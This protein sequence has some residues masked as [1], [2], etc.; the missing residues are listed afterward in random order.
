ML[1]FFENFWTFW[2]FWQFLQFFYLSPFAHCCS[3]EHLKT[4]PRCSWEASKLFCGEKEGLRRWL[5]EPVQTPRT[6]QITAVFWKKKSVYWP[7]SKHNILLV[8]ITNHKNKQVQLGWKLWRQSSYGSEDGGNLEWNLMAKFRL[9]LFL[10]EPA[11]TIL[12]A[13]GTANSFQVRPY[14]SS[15]NHVVV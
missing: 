13:Q 3:N 4:D 12:I 5:R 8:C 6:P 10:G 7:I 1:I 2:F 15:H 11:V 9:D 14:S